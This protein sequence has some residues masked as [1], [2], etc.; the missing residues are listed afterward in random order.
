MLLGYLQETGLF[1]TLESCISQ[2]GYQKNYFLNSDVES[3]RFLEPTIWNIIL[4]VL[5]YEH[6]IQF[7]TTVIFSTMWFQMII[8]LYGC[9]AGLIFYRKWT[10][11]SKMEIYRYSSLQSYIFHETINIAFK[12]S[13]A[14]FISYILFISLAYSVSS[15]NHL[16]GATG[17]SLF[18]DLIGNSLYQNHTYLYFVL[19][20]MIRFFLVP[21]VYSMFS[22]CIPLLN[23]GIKETVGAPLIYYYGMGMLG[24]ALYL[25]A[26]NSNFYVYISPAVIMSSGSFTNI[27]T[28]LMII[29]A[30][31]PLYISFAVIKIRCHDAEL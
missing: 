5:T 6:P 3:V 18:S 30:M 28:I 31:I 15:P 24:T 10:S 23:R 29:C 26:K 16:I 13:I 9:V 19:E 12:I 4:D 7:D 27:N 8:P 1:N 20:G 14:I 25:V 17:R 11:T 2:P 21:F 22:E